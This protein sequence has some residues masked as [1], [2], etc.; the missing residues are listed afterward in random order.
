MTRETKFSVDYSDLSDTMLK[1]KCVERVSES[2]LLVTLPVQFTV[3]LDEHGNVRSV[4][5]IG[6]LASTRKW[7]KHGVNNF[8]N[9]Y[10]KSPTGLLADAARAAKSR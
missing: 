5:Q 8:G 10:G 4:E 9:E 7:V 1:L 2:V 6:K 3:T